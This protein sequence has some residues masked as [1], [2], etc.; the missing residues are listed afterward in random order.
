MNILYIFLG[1]TLGNEIEPIIKTK[2]LSLRTCDDK[3]NPIGGSRGES[4]T[5]GRIIGGTAVTHMTS[6]SM[7]VLLQFKSRGKIFR[8]VRSQAGTVPTGTVPT[9]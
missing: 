4:D 2:P 3:Q 1:L 9:R 7:A 5:R 6:W 8:Y